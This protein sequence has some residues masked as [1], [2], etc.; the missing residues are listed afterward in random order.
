MTS[1][2]CKVLEKPVAR[3]ITDH[4]TKCN[5]TYEHQYGFRQNVGTMD[6]AAEIVT[7]VQ[8]SLDL[9]L[10]SGCLFLD[11]K[12]A[13]DSVNHHILVK[14]LVSAGIVESALSWFRSYLSGRYQSALVNGVMSDSRLVKNGVPQGSVLGPLLF[15]IAT[16]D[17]SN[18][19][20]N[21]RLVLF[22][23]DACVVYSS[24]ELN[25]LLHF[26]QEDLI[27]LTDW[28][29]RNGFS[30]NLSKTVY[31]LFSKNTINQVFPPVEVNGII[32]ERVS[33]FKYLGLMLDER[34]SWENH[35]DLIR[36]KVMPAVRILRRCR[37]MIHTNH[38]LTLYYSLIHSH[39]SYMAGI[40][41]CASKTKLNLLQV[42]QNR[43]LKAIFKLPIRTPKRVLYSQSRVPPIANCIK[44]S[45][46][47]LVFRSL[48]LNLH[49]SMFC[50]PA[51]P[52]YALRTVTHL[53][54][55]RCWSTKYGIHGFTF[56]SIDTYNKL[57]PEVKN[58]N[59][60]PA[61]KTG[62]KKYLYSVSL[63]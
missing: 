54:K 29:S 48:T 33:S 4:L 57:P 27:T 52:R 1:H 14:K 49:R 2:L 34:L 31:I 41:G 18:C 10:K 36:K 6:A 9:G 22:A 20:L 35:I 62:L 11:V 44:I 61:F 5:F 13:F 59:S 15:S 45:R 12:K 63:D 43:S 46:S 55:P 32:I 38:L 23:D 56:T 40:W 16:N 25:D 7:T 53:P 21:G 30:L 42:I 26:I 17:L 60:Y 58:V 50:L 19:K 28:Y 37:S 24:D 3:Q 39:F 47:L 51:D 8:K